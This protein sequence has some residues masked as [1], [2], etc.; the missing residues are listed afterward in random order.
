M[1]TT[2]AEE[3]AKVF[4]KFLDDYNDR[5]IRICL[6]G[7]T[8]SRLIGYQIIDLLSDSAAASGT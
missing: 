1:L 5:K 3:S 4:S 6:K 7:F 8:V 2:R